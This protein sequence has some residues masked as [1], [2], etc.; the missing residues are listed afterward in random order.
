MWSVKTIRPFL[1][2]TVSTLLL[3]ILMG[4]TAESTLVTEVNAQAAQTT[5]GGKGLIEHIVSFVNFFISLIIVITV[6]YFLLLLGLYHLVP[7]DKMTEIL[8]QSNNQNPIRTSFLYVVVI[9]VTYLLANGIFSL[10]T[11]SNT[12]TLGTIFL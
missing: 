8:S 7:E 11:G 9:V 2:I 5:G 3:L 4:G 10:V 1:L 12:F 6:G